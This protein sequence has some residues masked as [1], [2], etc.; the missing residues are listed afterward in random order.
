[1]DAATFA[2]SVFAAVPIAN[3]VFFSPS[4]LSPLPNFSS[5]RPE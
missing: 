4:P 2:L 5:L 1:M 3:F